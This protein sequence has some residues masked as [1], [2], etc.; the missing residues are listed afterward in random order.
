MEGSRNREN[1]VLARMRSI[2]ELRQAEEKATKSSSTET[3]KA[4]WTKQQ[5]EDDNDEEERRLRSETLRRQRANEAQSL[6]KQR[7][8]DA[9]AIFEQ[10]TSAGQLT[11]SRRSSSSNMSSPSPTPAA[12]NKIAAK[13][14]PTQSNG[15]V[16]PTPVS[17]NPVSPTSP[18]QQ[19]FV[20][21][22]F[23]SNR[24]VTSI[25]T[26]S[27][28][29]PP[30]RTPEPPATSVA[31]VPPAPA[32]ADTPP[33]LPSSSPPPSVEQPQSSSAPLSPAMALL[34]EV[35]EQNYEN[36]VGQNGEEDW[37]SPAYTEETATNGHD[38]YA[39]DP[40]E[41]DDQSLGVRARAIY[42]YQAGNYFYLII[43]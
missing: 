29:S 40:V 35:A 38:S 2:S 1:Q 7:S 37:E 12:S 33:Q 4:K 34:H 41:N 8:V 36:G 39:S 13:W 27:T 16:S 22:H 42:D 25:N 5:K 9:R 19:S 11:V 23:N 24:S 17:P 21:T 6:I 32:F 43:K 31:I 18:V 3:D 20:P 26:S 28:A 14:P 10:N 15:G 30:P